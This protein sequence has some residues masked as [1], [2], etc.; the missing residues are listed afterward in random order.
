MD[1]SGHD[2]HTP[3]TISNYHLKMSLNLLTDM[4][5]D[6]LTAKQTTKCTW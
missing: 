5:M 2:K 6:R 4:D 1:N 3:T